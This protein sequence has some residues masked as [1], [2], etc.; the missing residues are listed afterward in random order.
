MPV[1]EGKTSKHDGLAECSRTPLSRIPRFRAYFRTTESSTK[2]PA[3]AACA[4]ISTR[5]LACGPY[6]IR[7]VSRLC[8]QGGNLPGLM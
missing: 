8:R 3:D 7:I 2:L 5:G 6:T 4:Y 1:I